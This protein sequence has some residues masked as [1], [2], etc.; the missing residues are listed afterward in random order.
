[1]NPIV[2]YKD[3]S[4]WLYIIAAVVIC[5]VLGIMVFGSFSTDVK[6]WYKIFGLLAVIADV[7]S[8]LLGF[9]VMRYVYT[10]WIHP[11]YGD[12]T[13]LIVA[14]VIAIQVIHD[15]IYYFLLV[16]PWPRGA[17]AI[18]DYMY[19]Y[20]DKN[21]VYPILGDTV[22]VTSITITALVLSRL[23]KHVSIFVLM[24]GVYLIPYFLTNH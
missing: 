10:L 6:R 1:M 19:K 24:L 18:L 7:F 5:D 21:G 12:N 20:G 4:G 11:K 14:T 22:L 17:N 23:P 16:K 13:L 8:I 15:V 2:N 9:A 3:N